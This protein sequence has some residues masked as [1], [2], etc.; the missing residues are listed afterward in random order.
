MPHPVKET[1]RAAWTPQLP[2]VQPGRAPGAAVPVPDPPARG[3]GA[4]YTDENPTAALGALRLLGGGSQQDCT[5]TPT[6][7]QG[8]GQRPC[9]KDGPVASGGNHEKVRLRGTAGAPLASLLPGKARPQ[10]RSRRARVPGPGRKVLGPREER[11]PRC[12]R[13]RVQGGAACTGQAPGTAP[14]RRDVGTRPRAPAGRAAARGWTGGNQGSAVRRNERRT[15]RVAQNG[16]CGTPARWTQPREGGPGADGAA[17]G[18]A[19]AS[20]AVLRALPCA[21]GLVKN[22]LSKVTDRDTLGSTRR[23]GSAHLPH[24][25]CPVRPSRSRGSHAWGVATGAPGD[26]RFYHRVSRKQTCRF[27]A[28]QPTRG[29]AHTF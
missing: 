19:L 8:Q 11:E 9:P 29:A 16:A 17:A 20:Q 7:T 21:A 2:C 25:E 1:C 6:L 15:G 28:A 4:T 22:T 18:G 26:P 14:H 10:G 27:T 13:S 5:S 3:W 23:C 12:G 24:L